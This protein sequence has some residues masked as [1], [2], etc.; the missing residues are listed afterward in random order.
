[1]R[2]VFAAG[3]LVPAV[4]MSRRRADWRERRGRGRRLQHLALQ[5]Y[6]DTPGSCAR[7]LLAAA[8]WEMSLRAEFAERRNFY[9]EY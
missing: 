2:R 5:Y 7:G 3:V 8:P 6:P 9:T 4:G 1:M